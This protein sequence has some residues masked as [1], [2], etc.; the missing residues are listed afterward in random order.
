MRAK[1]VEIGPRDSYRFRSGIIGA[2]G[3]WEGE[4]MCAQDGWE[5]GF[6]RFDEPV[7]DHGL[8]YFIQVRVAPLDTEV[9][10]LKEPI[11]GIDILP[12]SRTDTIICHAIDKLNEGTKHDQGKLRMD[13]IPPEAERALAEVLT[14]GANKYEDRNWEKG[15]KYSRIYAA[16]RRH[17]LAWVEGEEIDPESKLSH[18]S[19]AFCCLAFLVT[20]ERRGMRENND[21]LPL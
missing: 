15:I 11:M 1:I 4:T 17:L 13:L 21:M 14:Y 7:E 16:L 18:L 19:H 12:T 10:I 20:Y 8:W 5:S 9:P 2:V 6:M 3:D